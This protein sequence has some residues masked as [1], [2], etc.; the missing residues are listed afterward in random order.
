MIKANTRTGIR[1]NTPTPLYFFSYDENRTMY[2]FPDIL[3]GA[4]VFVAKVEKNKRIN[5][6]TTETLPVST[7]DKNIYKE[8]ITLSLTDDKKNLKQC[9]T[10]EANG[11]HTDDYVYTRTSW[12]DFLRED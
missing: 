12:I 6:I 3:E 11:H 10:S 7:A 1:V 8:E 4:E 2:R 9:A 5:S